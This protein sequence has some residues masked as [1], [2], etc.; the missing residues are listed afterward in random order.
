MD[1][2]N[3]SIKSMLLIKGLLLLSLFFVGACAKCPRGKLCYPIEAVA[4]KLVD[5]DW[6][7]QKENRVDEYSWVEMELKYPDGTPASHIGYI[8][9]LI[10]GVK[11]EC[12]T[13]S[14]GFIR[15]EGVPKGKVI[16]KSTDENIKFLAN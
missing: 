4:G 8:L 12:I 6:T 15:L 2:I 11:V 14:K 5:I 9:T 16:F 13:D 7:S 10:D 1:G 3:H